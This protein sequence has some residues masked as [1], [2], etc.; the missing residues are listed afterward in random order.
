ML[1]G[2]QSINWAIS[3]H[4]Q[5]VLSGDRDLT[6]LD[7][8]MADGDAIADDYWAEAFK[9]ARESVGMETHLVRYAR[10]ILEWCEKHRPGPSP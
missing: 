6:W 2:R 4:N 1:W 7:L 5:D 10:K 3:L 9:E 8:S